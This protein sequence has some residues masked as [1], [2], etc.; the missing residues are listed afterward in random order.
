MGYDGKFYLSVDDKNKFEKCKDDI[1][2]EYNEL[3]NVQYFPNIGCRYHTGPQGYGG[4]YWP[5]RINTF[6]LLTSKFPDIT[7]T[8]SLTC[9]DNTIIYITRI[10]N[11]TVLVEN[12][13]NME[14]YEIIPGVFIRAEINNL[15]TA[16]GN[17]TEFFSDEEN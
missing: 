9:H 2:R 5:E 14:E 15:F 4:W 11:Q 10:R 1:M 16:E 8:L 3:K 17:V 13:I 7:F 6:K 12:V